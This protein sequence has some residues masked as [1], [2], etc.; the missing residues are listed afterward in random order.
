[1]QDFPKRNTSEM[2]RYHQIEKD[3][4]QLQESEDFSEKVRLKF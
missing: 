3:I 2:Y 4:K 1:M